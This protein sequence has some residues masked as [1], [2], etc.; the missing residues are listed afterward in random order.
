MLFRSLIQHLELTERIRILP[1]PNPVM[2]RQL[3]LAYRKDIDP[4]MRDEI[5][6]I[7]DRFYK[8]TLHPEIIRLAPWLTASLSASAL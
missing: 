2:Q 4:Q 5:L 1:M 7:S 8:E 3:I 6:S